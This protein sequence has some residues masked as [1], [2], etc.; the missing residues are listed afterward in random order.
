MES[1]RIFI[2]DF[3]KNKGQHVFLSLLIAK[4]CAFVGSL[5]IIRFLP[6]NEF[7][8]ISIVASVFAIF[9]PFSGFGSQQ[10]LLRYGSLQ[11]KVENKMMLSKFLLKEGFYKQ[12]FLSFIFLAVAFVYIEK[13]EDIVLL[14]IFFTIRLIG[15]YFFNHLQSEA[16]VFGNNLRFS[17]LTNTV[18]LV[19][20]FLLL[21]L[22]YFFGLKGYLIAIAVTPFIALFWFRRDLYSHLK[23][24]PHSMN[25][26]E[27]RKYGLY[28][29]GT[30]LLS[31]TL[32]SADVLLLS[33]LMNA[34]AVA[35]YKVAILIPANITFLSLTFMQSDFPLLAKNYRDK[36]FLKNYIANYYKIF[37]P[38]TA[39][40]LIVGFIFRSEIL[41]LFFSIKYSGNSTIFIILLAGFCFN[42]LL[43]NLYG[44]LLS[45]VGRMKTN[46]IISFITLLLLF[47]FSFIFVGRMGVMGMAISL[48]LSMVISGLLLTFSFYL[49][50]K[51]LK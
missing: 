37:I 6:E 3:F 12:L 30:A 9:L 22:T 42:M 26:K 51:D 36:K 16:R 25:S 48:T 29:A 45:A 44:N 31:D 8:M 40:I 17:Q 20:L 32:F 41:S 19:G 43:R 15:F 18:N 13:Y 28:S 35:N 38:I 14:F 1:L 4:I 24:E 10:S 46:T 50:W 47:S 7:G 34:V 23:S 39:T 11:A 21:F 2:T 5:L 33:F 49:Y 27:M